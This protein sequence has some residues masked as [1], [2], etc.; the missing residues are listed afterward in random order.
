[1][2]TDEGGTFIS[3]WS[4]RK[5]AARQGA[6][7][8]PAPSAP[9]HAPPAASGAAEQPER[10]KGAGA[11]ALP[12]VDELR[13]LES[14]YRDFLRPEVD[15]SLRRTALKRLFADPHFNVMD[16]L[17]VY[18][19]DYSKPDPIEPAMLRMLN[20]ARGLR[21][22]DDSERAAEPANRDAASQQTSPA[23]VDDG[24]VPVPP[25]AASVPTDCPGETKSPAAGAYDD[26]PARKSG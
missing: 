16:G 18:I 15:E 23:S 13:G 14:E 4:R 25:A 6:V 8:E 12:D 20:Q 5:I 2:S 1:M 24:A 10:E 19:D 22:F 17:D 26:K 9:V 7:V 3:R 11:P 21:L